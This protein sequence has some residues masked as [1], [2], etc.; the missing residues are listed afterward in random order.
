MF[1]SWFSG[2]PTT[3]KLERSRLYS[4]SDT[5]VPYI[6]WLVVRFSPLAATDTQRLG[7]ITRSY[8]HTQEVA[9]SNMSS[10][11][12][13]RPAWHRGSSGGGRGFQPPP[14]VASSRPKSVG[15]KKK[16]FNKFSALD[17]D[18]DVA[19][20]EKK[21]EE[22]ARR[23][24][25]GNSRS[26]GLRSARPSNKGRSLADLAARAPDRERSGSYGSAGDRHANGHHHHIEENVIRY[27]TTTL[28]TTR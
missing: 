6:A 23:L 15:E 27:T 16:N 13:L 21:A 10:P 3:L 20:M 24:A 18:E 25:G 4:L 2:D 28:L 12:S 7:T 5:S 11:S 14:T 8:K 17:D 1:F 22:T 9:S 26:E 19:T